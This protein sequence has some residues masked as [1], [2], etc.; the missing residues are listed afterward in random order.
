MVEKLIDKNP[1]ISNYNFRST[2]KA[3]LI[4][5]F[6]VVGIVAVLDTF[7]I[8]KLAAPELSQVYASGKAV[9]ILTS[10]FAL[11]SMYT[12][13]QAYVGKALGGLF[14]KGENLSEH[15]VQ[16]SVVLLPSGV[17]YASTSKGLQSKK[18]HPSLLGKIEGNK[19]EG[20]SIDRINYRIGDRTTAVLQFLRNITVEKEGKRIRI[21]ATQVLF[22]YN[23]IIAKTRYRIFMT[24][25]LIT[26]ATLLLVPILVPPA[27]RKHRQMVEALQQVARNNLDYRLPPAGKDEMGTLYRVYNEM[28]DSLKK[29]V[30]E[31]AKP[32]FN[33]LQNYYDGSSKKSANL[34]LR[35]FDITCLC[36][37]IPGIQTHI[38][39]HEPDSISAFV[40]D[41]MN[42]VKR[43]IQMNGGQAVKIIGDK[44]FFL[45]EG[46]NSMDNAIRAAL[47]CHLVWLQQNH[48]RKVH[49]KPLL[50]Y[51]IG[52]HSAIGSAGKVTSSSESFTL[53]GEAAAIA[54]FLCSFADREEMLITASMIEKAN[55]TYPHQTVSNPVQEHLPN[56][57]IFLLTG[58]TLEESLTFHY[59]QRNFE[60]GENSPDDNSSSGSRNAVKDGSSIPDIL[61]E[62]LSSTP[63]DLAE[64][65]RESGYGPSHISDGE[66]FPEENLASFENYLDE[67]DQETE[68]TKSLWDKV[69]SEASTKKE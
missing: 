45:F 28:A 7:F 3:L 27:S 51:G 10:E 68:E 36:A 62:T 33:A 54:D 37:R 52:L 40:D 6:I 29:T 60:R 42:A 39:G 65:K 26:V 1:E 30:A 43:S 47:K 55:E 32:S 41:Y 50:N 67:G 38:E 53:I 56:E 14:E 44:V 34:V 18:V 23:G 21:A 4:A 19:M 48:E 69:H 13:R 61:E 63:L 66:R 9:S 8:E 16:I 25:L 31:R 64:E 59:S 12:R 5:I 24:G 11:G 46:V 35:K 15:L 58:G 17:Y 49:E 20:T 22:D 2:I 57:E